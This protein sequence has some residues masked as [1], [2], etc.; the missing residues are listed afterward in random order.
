VADVRFADELRYGTPRQPVAVSLT[1]LP[2]EA[3]SRAFRIACGLADA[4]FHSIVVEGQ[5]SRHRF[6]SDMIE[7]RSL[8]APPKDRDGISRRGGALRNG[9]F[10]WSGELA[11]YAAFRCREY[12][13]NYR[14]PSWII[15]RADLYYLHSFELHRAIAARGMPIIYDA[16]DF[17]RAIEPSDRQPSFDRNH[18]RPFL[19]RLEDRLVASAAAFVT[20]SEGVAGLMEETFKRRPAVIRNCHDTRSD[21]TIVPDLRARLRL[22]PADRLAVVVGNLKRGMAIDVA[23]EALAMLPDHFHLAFVGGFYEAYRDRMRGHPAAAR[24]HFGHRVLPDEVVPFIRSADLG[25]VIYEG[26]CDNSRWM[27][28]NGFFQ[29]VAAGLPLVRGSLPEIESTIAGHPVGIC[30]E[31]L[32]PHALAAAIR[33]CVAQAPM[34]R[35]ASAALG[36]E[37]R[38]EREA[39]RLHRLIDAVLPH[40]LRA[41]D[42]ALQPAR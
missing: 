8:A 38:W 18:L 16:H 23:V 6:W 33:Q 1:P 31:R 21:R 3:D 24:L 9:R 36:R 39:V 22:S 2:L 20:V 35:P 27:L 41:P 14:Q 42:S 26:Y 32:D 5:A 40:R 10:G 13:R 12:W 25:L 19:N 7:V 15:L 30:L 4:G 17:Y 37:L 29:I 11:L 34:L 28:P